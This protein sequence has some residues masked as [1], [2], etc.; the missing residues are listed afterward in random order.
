MELDQS[1][2][3]TVTCRITAATYTHSTRTQTIQYFKAFSF[4]SVSCLI[5]ILTEESLFCV[6]SEG[7]TKVTVQKNRKQTAH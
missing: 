3:P 7:I 1:D 2:A 6:L 5:S 4:F